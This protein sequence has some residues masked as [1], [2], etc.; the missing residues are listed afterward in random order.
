MK[1]SST[2]V[3]DHYYDNHSTFVTIHPV[4]NVTSALQSWCTEQCVSLART[5]SCTGSCGFFISRTFACRSVQPL[6]SLYIHNIPFS[7]LTTTGPGE[8]LGYVAIPQQG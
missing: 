8:I 1:A 5:A 4:Q 2:F 6:V 7:D 3:S